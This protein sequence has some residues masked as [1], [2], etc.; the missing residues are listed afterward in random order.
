MSLAK[1]KESVQGKSVSE[2][3]T[4]GIVPNGSYL[5]KMGGR[6]KDN[7]VDTTYTD[8]QTGEEKP[9]VIWE[10]PVSFEIV[11]P[12]YNVDED[13]WQNFSDVNGA[14]PRVTVKINRDPQ[15]SMVLEQLVSAVDAMDEEFENAIDE[16]KGSE[17]ILTVKNTGKTDSRGEPMI[18]YYFGKPRD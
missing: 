6:G 14:N 2:I 5:A 4:L 13:D 16:N 18:N 9:L 7:E 12:A 3:K 1:L 11:E 10:T 17:V 8:K 15:W